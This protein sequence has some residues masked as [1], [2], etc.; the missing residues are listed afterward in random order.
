MTRRTW[1]RHLGALAATLALSGCQIFQNVD[2]VPVPPE[3]PAALVPP[4]PP[5][6]P[7]VVRPSAQSQ[8]LASYFT[9][10]EARLVAQGL[11]RTDGGGVDT[12]YD[13][14][15]LMENFERIAFYDEYQRGAGLTAA[16]GEIGRLKKWS[17]PIRFGVEFGARVPEETRAADRAEVARYVARLARLTGHPMSLDDTAP[18]FHVLYMSEDDAPA[19]PGRIRAIVPNIN[20]TA[21]NIFRNL[22]RDIHCLVIAFSGASG[23]YDYARAIALIRTEHP[24]LLRRSCVHEEIAQGLGLANDS[25]LARP[26]IFN[27]DDEFALLTSHDEKLLRILYTPALRPGMSL[28]EARPIIRRVAAELMGETDS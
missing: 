13:A 16:R 20:E 10:L 19:L 6:A 28:Q 18:N 11:L 1:H 27:D 8:A 15:I 23:S 2:P 3:R 21:L 5:P 17:V 12:S 24:N 26:S 22:P 14:R 25:P 9:R 4:P 7:T